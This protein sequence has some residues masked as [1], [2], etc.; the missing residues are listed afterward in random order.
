MHV[1]SISGNTDAIDG[2]A[3]A[4]YAN[5]WPADTGLPAYRTSSPPD[6]KERSG[7]LLQSFFKPASAASA[8]HRPSGE[9]REPADETLKLACWALADFGPEKAADPDVMKVVTSV[10]HRFDVIALQQLRPTQRDLLPRMLRE[11]NRSGRHYDYLAGPVHTRLGDNRGEQLVFFFDTERVVTDR[12]Q[13]Y[14]PADPER[15]LSFP[16]LVAWFRA[17]GVDPQ[18]AWT[19]SMVNMRVELSRAHQEVYELPNLLAAVQNDGRGE[20]D[21]ILTGL[22]Q[23]DHVYLE[24]TLGA[25][26]YETAVRDKPTDVVAKHQTSNIIIDRR[27]TSEAVGRSG[28][29]DFLRAHNLSIAQ[30]QKVSPYLP[31]YAEF[32]AWEGG[33]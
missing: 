17:A 18:R 1:G 29:Y 12:T 23:A 31:V 9:R 33:Y 4:S 2:P 19:F 10:V 11:I 6:A 16:P 24:A 22:F 21:V 20:D 7:G 15:R 3:P 27:R 30:A 25:P 8:D 26:R 32:T 14:T 13:L 28:V 5:V